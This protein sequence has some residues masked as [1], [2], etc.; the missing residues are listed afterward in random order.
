MMVTSPGNGRTLLLA[1]FIAAWP[2]GVGLGTLAAGFIAEY[3]Q[4]LLADESRS[5]LR[6]P[7]L[8]GSD[9][10]QKFF[11]L[12]TG[13]TGLSFLSILIFVPDDRPDRVILKN[14]IDWLGNAFFFISL[15]F[16]LYVLSVAPG[17]K[18]GWATPCESI[19]QSR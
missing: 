3:V 14:K 8:F 7:I 13:I 12:L 17:S 18:E 5:D 9:N 10:W 16:I 11:Y 19:V 2:T 1:C 6:A 15:F 4:A